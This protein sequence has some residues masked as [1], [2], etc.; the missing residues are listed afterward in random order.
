MDRRLVTL[1]V[2]S[3]GGGVIFHL[4]EMTRHFVGMVNIKHCHRDLTVNVQWMS[5]DFEF[6]ATGVFFVF[7]FYPTWF[8]KIGILVK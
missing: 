6:A 1:C 5:C 2:N 4:R 7:V 8:H 3:G